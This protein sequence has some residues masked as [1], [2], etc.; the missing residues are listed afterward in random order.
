MNHDFNHAKPT[1]R[2]NICLEIKEV[3]LKEHRPDPDKNDGS[4][5]TMSYCQ[6]CA[7]ENWLR[8]MA[9]EDLHA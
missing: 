9:S 5:I 6:D 4:W 7:N 3:V 2:C 8:R 1:G